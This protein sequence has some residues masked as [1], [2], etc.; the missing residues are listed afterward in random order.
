MAIKLEKNGEVVYRDAIE[1]VIKHG[2]CR[3]AVM[4]G[5]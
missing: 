2:A 1:K 5:R 4:D 3:F